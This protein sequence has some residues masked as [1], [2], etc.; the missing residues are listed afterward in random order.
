MRRIKDFWDHHLPILM[1]V[2]SGYAYWAVEHPAGNVIAGDE[3]EYEEVSML[4]PSISEAHNLIV[5]QVPRIQL[6][7]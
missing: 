5:A 4:G 6:W 3:P 2:K 7:V 1:S